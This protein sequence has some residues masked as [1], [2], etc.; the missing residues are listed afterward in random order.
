MLRVDPLLRD[1]K[2]A[3]IGLD[4]EGRIVLWNRGAERLYGYTEAEAMNL[5]IFDITPEQKREEI[6]NLLQEIRDGRRI[7]SIE[8]SRLTRHGR[9][10][11]VWATITEIFD[12]R[13]NVKEI[14]SCE[15]DVSGHTRRLDE[16]ETTLAMAEEYAETIE[17]LVAER[18]A[19]LIALNIADRITNPAFVIGIVCKRLLGRGIDDP[20]IIEGL[21]TIL[22]ESD[23][24]KRIVHE[25]NELVASKRVSFQY[26]DINMVV[27]EALMLIK[28][29]AEDRGIS[30]TAEVSPAPI[31]VNMNRSI[32]RT[33]IYYL[34]RNA[35]EATPPGGSIVASTSEDGN[36]AY[37]II[38]DTGCGISE[39]HI[40]RI[41]DNFF[42]TK[43]NALG[44]GLPFVRHIV[45]EHLG[46]IKI[47]SKKGEGTKC[48]ITIPLR[49]IKIS[50]GKLLWDT[51]VL[52]VIYGK[53]DYPPPMPSESSS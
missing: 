40:N 37:V 43:E 4:L 9:V 16:F 1:I 31:R 17:A 51:S 28:K 21:S 29:D 23:K 3:I 20:Y 34:L 36:N 27:K 49:W 6:A 19:S 45:S 48:T 25:F 15:R 33:A 22:E 47:E 24:L 26:D 46:D 42:T 10:I 11:D 7:D 5:T 8:T 18:T 38:T 13:G 35:L 53:K 2:D 41:F 32:F 52:P 12:E 30:L 44:M 14:V 50:E 39:E